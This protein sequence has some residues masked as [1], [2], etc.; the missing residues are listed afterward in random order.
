MIN[1]YPMIKY[2]F[3]LLLSSLA[4]TSCIFQKKKISADDAFSK[5]HYALAVE[6]Y[7][8]SINP[9]YDL[10]ARD[11][12]RL[13]KSYENL[14]QY[15]DA[16][17]WYKIASE[18]KPSANNT[19]IYGLSLMRL[20]RYRQATTVFKK[21]VSDFGA[22]EEVK[23]N[24]ERCQLAAKWKSD[25]EQN[26]YKVSLGNMNTIYSDYSP[27]YLGKDIFFSSDR[28]ESTG[29]TEYSWTGNSFSDIFI[30]S[31]S[32]VNPYQ[33]G[34]NTEE[35]EGTICFNSA[36]DEIFFTRCDNQINEDRYCK[37]MFTRLVE[38]YWEK[39]VTMHFFDDKVNEVHPCLI[40]SD[41]VLIFAANPI[42][43][44]GG[45][46]LYYSVREADG[47]SSAYSMPEYLNSVG[48]E[49]FPTSHHDT[50]YYS[51]DYLV[52][53]GGLDIFKTYL[54]KSNKWK[55]PQN[56]KAP[57]NSGYDD[58]SLV[59]NPNFNPN[60]IASQAG[61]FSSNRPGGR[62][63]DDIYNYI[64]TIKIDDQPTKEDKEKDS[65]I[66][67]NVFVL[68]NIFDNEKNQ[69]DNIT[70]LK[71]NNPVHQKDKKGKY[72]FSP[73]KNESY[74]FLF[75]KK[76]YLSQSKYI[77]LSDEFYSS[78]KHD[79]TL[80]Y[81]IILQSYEVNKEIILNN[82]YYDYDK[83]NLRPEAK[84][85][86][87]N[88]VKILNDNPKIKIELASHTDCH[89]KEDYNIKLSQ[90]RAQSVVDYL[91]KN[92]VNNSRLIAKGYGESR[93]IDKC[94][95]EDCTDAGRQLNRRTSFK[96]LDSL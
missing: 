77:K 63:L 87:D 71:N 16:M 30:K 59:V 86:L 36:G 33:I 4:L 22:S 47:W 46:D 54:Q 50:L 79:T 32:Q 55:N 64:K 52:G 38:G 69:L 17:K 53:M 73:S 37:L 96:I 88:L 83:Y 62:G 35:N 23:R 21:L 29:G 66:S 20:E 25:Q 15:E 74:T 42:N 61:L 91:I 3:L 81:A 85:S 5:K 94:K 75:E 45:Y 93:P 92:G 70:I 11:A 78:L 58:F 51:S 28:P 24:Q 44:I 82:I 67:Y 14:M 13:G 39:P 56:L 18:E 48:D 27:F 68:F 34:I 76:G 6:L 2:I 60:I 65:I 89:G 49:K 1:D 72:F 80:N 31:K 7:K 12:Y 41:S 90:N 40:E 95:C 84:K 19:N 43:S 10:Y 8:E 57:I 26:P 9:N